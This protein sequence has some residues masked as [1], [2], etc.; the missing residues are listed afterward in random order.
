MQE[1]EATKAPGDVR[2]ARAVTLQTHRSVMQ[3][4]EPLETDGGERETEAGK[5]KRQREKGGREGEMK[6]EGVKRKGRGKSRVERG[7]DRGVGGESER[8]RER[9]MH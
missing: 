2:S 5:R 9:E 1:L 3:H 8:Q 6:S 4:V 7:R